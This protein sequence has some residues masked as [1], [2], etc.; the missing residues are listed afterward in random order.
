V[1][2]DGHPETLNA[3]NNLA[4]SLARRG[5]REEAI[6]L[7]RRAR[8][9]ALDLFGPESYRVAMITHNLARTLGQ[10]GAVEEADAEFRAAIDLA[11]RAFP[12]GNPTVH[13]FRANHGELLLR[14][15]RR[16]E[17]EELLAPAAEELAAALGEDHPRTAAAREWLA[18][19]RRR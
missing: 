1:L 11:E 5:D 6:P 9:T 18:E 14:A 16:A 7:F 8:E 12:A 19:A 13:I 17:A 2:G 15:G 3:E 10:A 4:T